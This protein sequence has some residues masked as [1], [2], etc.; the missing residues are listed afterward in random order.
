MKKLTVA[1]LAA[2]LGLSR[3]GLV[4]AADAGRLGP[5][6]RTPGRHRRFDP[7]TVANA[8]RQREATVPDALTRLAAEN[9]TGE[10]AA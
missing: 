4:A 10:C 1:Q 9:D 6:E 5:V 8:L 2:I 3:D 7:R